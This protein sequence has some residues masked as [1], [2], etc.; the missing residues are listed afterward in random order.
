MPDVDRTPKPCHHPNTQHEHGTRACYVHDKCRCYPCGAANSDYA[1]NLNRQRV[2]GRS[3]LVDA[4]PARLHVK[5]LQAGGMGWRQVAKRAEVSGSGV[6]ALLHDKRG[7]GPTKRLRK[8]TAERLLAV[9]LDLADH[10]L[11]DATIYV[12]RLRALVALGYSQAK[13]ARRLGITPSNFTPVM[14]GSR[15]ALL[16]ATSNAIRPLYA[17]LS[18]TPPPE[19]THRERCSATRARNM[20]QARG[21]VPPLA[22]DDEQLDDPAAQPAGRAIA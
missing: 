13:L 3:N 5:K 7:R 2:Y 4:E 14:D 16:V 8:E 1:A 22:W 12:R 9:Q 21:W 15:P 19:T 18:M 10:A 6:Y 17:E 11:V 20:A